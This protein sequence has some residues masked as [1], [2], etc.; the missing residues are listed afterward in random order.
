M[1]VFEAPQYLSNSFN[2]NENTG[3]NGEIQFLQVQPKMLHRQH[4]VPGL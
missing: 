3:E 1:C 4:M 2:D